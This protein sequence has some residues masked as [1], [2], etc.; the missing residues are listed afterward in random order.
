MGI[1]I[2][3]VQWH[4]T[5]SCSIRSFCSTWDSSFQRGVERSGAMQNGGKGRGKGGG[6]GGSQR[7]L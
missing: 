3:R 1:D 4:S 6:G 2:S 7:S 5:S